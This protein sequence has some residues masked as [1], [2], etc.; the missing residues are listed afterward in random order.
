M[1]ADRR[2]VR[3][4]LVTLKQ[5]GLAAGQAVPAIVRI[6]EDNSDRQLR[7][8]AA[9]ALKGI[10]PGARAALPALLS[11]LEGDVAGVRQAIAVALGAIGEAAENILASGCRSLRRHASQ[12]RVR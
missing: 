10:G 1:L 2:V 8:Y 6:L 4:A 3:T 5:I 7:W 11:T 12:L 9:D